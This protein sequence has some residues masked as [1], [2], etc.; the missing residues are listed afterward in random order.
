MNVSASRGRAGALPGAPV[1]RP[2]TT[3]PVAPR[4]SPPAAAGEGNGSAGSDPAAVGSGWRAVGSHRSTRARSSSTSTSCTT[5]C[6]TDSRSSTADSPG[7]AARRS[8]SSAASS[9]RWCRSTTEQYWPQHEPSARTSTPI[10]N[11][12]WRCPWWPSR[13]RPVAVVRPAVA[14]VP[15]RGAATDRRTSERRPKVGNRDRRPSQ[16]RGQ[17]RQQADPAGCRSL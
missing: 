10:V 9:M 7:S 16:A 1:P 14:G 12:P 11:G 4:L 3:R 8:G 15:C 5:T 2:V 6:S 13:R 17:G